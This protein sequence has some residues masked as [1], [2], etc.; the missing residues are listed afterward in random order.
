MRFPKY[1]WLQEQPDTSE[2]CGFCDVLY[3]SANVNDKFQVILDSDN[4]LDNQFTENPFDEITSTDLEFELTEN[5]SDKQLQLY[6]EDKTYIFEYANTGGGF[7]DYT[8]TDNVY[9]VLINKAGAKD[10]NLLEFLQ[11]IFDVNHGTTSSES[12]S[13][14]TIEDIPSGSYLNNYDFVD[15]ISTVTAS[16][17]IG[18]YFYWKDNKINYW[19][20]FDT[21]N[22]N[23]LYK[24]EQALSAST[25]LN[26]KIGYFSNST[27]YDVTITISD[28]VDTQTFTPTL[29]LG[30]G[31]IEINFYP[32]NTATYDITIEI[33]DV[34]T[35]GSGLSFNSI[36]LDEVIGLED[37]S[38]EDCDGNID[39]A[40]TLEI[41][42][43]GDVAIIEFT[44]T[45]PS[46]FRFIFT[47]TEENT[48]TSRWYKLADKDDCT[49]GK[50]Y[51]IK[52]SN[53]CNLGE[54]NYVD[55]SQVNE[56]L[57]SGVLIKGNSEVI[58]SVDN[59]TASGKKIS[60]YKNIQSV[61]ELRLH[62]YLSET[63]ENIL[64]GIFEH[65]DVTV[66][67][68]SFNTVD[69]MQTSEIDLG[70]YTS[71]IDLYKSG[72]ELITKSCC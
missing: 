17:N 56:L 39:I 52:W 33:D 42:Y 24:F 5:N 30:T 49:Y 16:T 45:Y 38:V 59:V 34:E 15:N 51:Q 31:T 8:L 47:D 48:L 7:Y 36:T 65:S 22:D 40:P 29:N 69:T 60:V 25:L 2:A 61:Y 46:V 35:I 13:V 23:G 3:K 72:T 66:N 67:G 12:S 63:F 53:D 55:S 50:L 26:L 70:I 44:D 11:D 58:D 68:V 43:I 71:R 37:V 21:N 20:N 27:T 62:P 1:Q 41:D 57:L 18:G 32:V 64:E 28:G 14:F 6:V 10:N 4:L 9:Y 54:I 19:Q